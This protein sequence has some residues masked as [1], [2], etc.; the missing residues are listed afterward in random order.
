[1]MRRPWHRLL[2][3]VLIVALV[4]G[5]VAVAA[6][7]LISGL[8]CGLHTQGLYCSPCLSATPSKH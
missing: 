1:M 5:A 3:T 6:A 4:Y 7:S 2:V 8:A